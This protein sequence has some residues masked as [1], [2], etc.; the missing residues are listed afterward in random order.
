MF[1]R[2]KEDLLQTLPIKFI[3]NSFPRGTT[4]EHPLRVVFSLPF[5][6]GQRVFA[7]DV[8]FQFVHIIILCKWE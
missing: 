1:D 2:S 4:R 5:Y 8:C 7:I 3:I 6:F